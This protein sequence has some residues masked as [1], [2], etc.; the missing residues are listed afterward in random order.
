MNANLSRPN[1]AGATSLLHSTL[2]TLSTC[3]NSVKHN[4]TFGFDPSS[5]DIVSR[6][7]ETCLEDRIDETDSM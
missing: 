4:E 6:S 1:M 5:Q 7:S 3:V 2:G